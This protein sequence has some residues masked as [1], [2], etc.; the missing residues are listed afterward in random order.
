MMKGIDSV[1]QREKAVRGRRGLCLVAVAALLLGLAAAVPAG[2]ARSDQLSPSE[3]EARE[4][5]L[6]DRGDFLELLREAEQRVSATQLSAAV[7]Y[8]RSA[9][10]RADRGFYSA[11]LLDIQRAIG[12][13]QRALSGSGGDVLKQ[14]AERQLNRFQE[15]LAEADSAAREYDTDS[16][17]RML[18]RAHREM[19]QARRA[20]EAGRYYDVTNSVRRGT[21]MAQE[22][23]RLARRGGL[24]SAERIQERLRDMLRIM[25][26]L[27]GKARDAAGSV[28]SPEV[29]EIAAE[30]DAM[31]ARA[32]A[33]AGAG[34][35]ETAIRV[36]DRA[37]RIARLVLR[38]TG[39]GNQMPPDRLLEQLEGLSTLIHRASALSADRPE[40]TAQALIN[41]ARSLRSQAQDAIHRGDYTSAEVKIRTATEKVIRALGILGSESGEL[42]V[43]A[44]EALAQLRDRY[45][46]AAEDVLQE[47]PDSTQALGYL[48]R[49]RVLADRAENEIASGQAFTAL[50][51][52]RIAAELTIQAIRQAAGTVEPFVSSGG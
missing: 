43:R 10:M 45:I 3:E 15:V 29:Q 16:V 22:A 40:P 4:R 24:D 8:Y 37:I 34:H 46:P 52:I 50:N 13:V 47:Y 28:G 18:G 7:T 39:M 27:A 51:S 38:E 36:A 41:E 48:D 20:L 32:H 1:H 5:Y 25:D 21:Q 49:A 12:E 26:D 23:Y 6:S 14:S 44:R 42:E 31:T 9:E 2:P 17:Q 19:E 35:A 30:L 33:A 11:A